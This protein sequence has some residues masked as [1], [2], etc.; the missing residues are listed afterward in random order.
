MKVSES[1]L[2]S[3]LDSSNQL[4]RIP[5]PGP[6]GSSPI[7]WEDRV[8]LT[9]C[10]TEKN[11][12]RLLCLD[13]RDGSKVWDRLVLESPPESIHN[14]NSRA[15]GTPATDGKAVYVAF[16]LARG[17][18]IIAPKTTRNSFAVVS[19]VSRATSIS[20]F[21]DNAPRK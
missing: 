1:G 17:E 4:W 18:K 11:E 9:T 13:R 12:R 10:L 19:V 15:S 21:Q 7:V 8:F 14:L 3:K 2:P 6:G 16:M 5:L 20:T